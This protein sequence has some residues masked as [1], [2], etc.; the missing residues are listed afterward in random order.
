MLLIYIFSFAYPKKKKKSLLNTIYKSLRAFREMVEFGQL[1]GVNGRVWFL[2]WITST[3]TV[4][5]GENRK[6]VK[7][8]I[9][10]AQA[11]QCPCALCLLSI[12]P[13]LLTNNSGTVDLLL[14]YCT[15]WS[16]IHFREFLPF[17]QLCFWPLT[18][19]LSYGPHSRHQWMVRSFMPF[20]EQGCWKHL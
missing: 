5:T 9:K 15:V 13:L 1:M 4:P 8:T 14:G 18:S 16:C 20:W 12:F 10:A 17:L 6:C 2:N 11:L 19:F 7:T 3:S